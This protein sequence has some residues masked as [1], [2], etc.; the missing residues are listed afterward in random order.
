MPAC[1][2]VLGVASLSLL[3]FFGARRLYTCRFH[4]AFVV[5]SALAPSWFRTCRFWS[6]FV[7]LQTRGRLGLG[8]ER[9]MRCIGVTCGSL[10]SASGLLASHIFAAAAGT[11]RPLFTCLLVS[12][13]PQDTKLPCSRR[14][15]PCERRRRTTMSPV[16]QATVETCCQHTWI[17]AEPHV[18]CS[19]APPPAP[20]GVH[21][22]T[23][24]N[25][26]TSCCRCTP[27]DL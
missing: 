5:F 18:D 1:Q 23:H 24:L 11:A 7:V 9:Y 25:V 4:F 12:H 26:R 27:A 19:C 15:S 6:Y 22:G 10:E 20:R 3:Q 2:A 13:S 21:P 16:Y 17:R 14:C 8:E